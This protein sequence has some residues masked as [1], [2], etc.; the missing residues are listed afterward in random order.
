MATILCVEGCTDQ[1]VNAFV[2]GSYQEAGWNHDRPVY[3]KHEKV[4][5]VPIYICFWDGRHGPDLTGWWFGPEVGGTK[6]WARGE[7]V[8]SPNHGWRIPY[9]GPADAS[10]VVRWVG[11]HREVESQRSS[12]PCGNMVIV[13]LVRRAACMRNGVVCFQAGKPAGHDEFLQLCVR[14]GLYIFGDP[15]DRG[16]ERV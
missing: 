3:V 16:W 2:K 9:D 12:S 6:V 1:F 15:F 10:F 11:D 4:I 14:L 13:R 8:Y 5:G 7:D